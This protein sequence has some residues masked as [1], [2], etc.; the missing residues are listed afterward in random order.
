MEPMCPEPGILY[1]CESVMLLFQLVCYGY[2][3]M[4]YVAVVLWNLCLYGCV[5]FTMLILESCMA[6]NLEYSIWRCGA[7][8]GV[9]AWWCERIIQVNCCSCDDYVTNG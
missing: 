5:A 1:G 9:Q 4:A 6:A 2:V 7:E 8:V 3:A